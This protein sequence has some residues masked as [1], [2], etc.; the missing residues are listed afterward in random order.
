MPVNR[1]QQVRSS[2]SLAISRLL[3][4]FL[5]NLKEKDVLLVID[6][7]CLNRTIYNPD[8]KMRLVLKDIVILEGMFFRK[9]RE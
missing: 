4:L 2:S 3:L 9:G 5:I 1:R 8:E 7:D 6:G